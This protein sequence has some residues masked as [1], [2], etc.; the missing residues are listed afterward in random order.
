[1]LD[2]FQLQD[3][4]HGFK[5]VGLVQGPVVQRIR[6]QGFSVFQSF[7]SLYYH[8]IADAKSSAILLRQPLRILVTQPLQYPHKC[9]NFYKY[10]NIDKII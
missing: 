7:F 2:R 3:V 5:L 1:M 9:L 4:Y 8:F 6:I 10:N